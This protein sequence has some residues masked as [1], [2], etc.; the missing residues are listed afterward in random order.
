MKTIS[1]KKLIEYIKCE[2][3]AFQFC[4]GLM[5]ITHPNESHIDDVLAD[6]IEEMKIFL[7][8]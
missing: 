4:D 2:E 7:I 5:C 8:N 1:K 3:I 6:D